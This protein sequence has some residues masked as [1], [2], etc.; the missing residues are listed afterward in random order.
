MPAFRMQYLRAKAP[1]VWQIIA[2]INMVLAV[3]IPVK[4]LLKENAAGIIIPRIIMPNQKA[5]ATLPA[6]NSLMENLA[7]ADV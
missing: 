4:I 3:S 1:K 5:K 2:R 7:I 6:T